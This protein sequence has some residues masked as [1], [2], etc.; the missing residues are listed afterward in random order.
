MIGISRIVDSPRR[1]RDGPGLP[2]ILVREIRVA[3]D[4]EDERFKLSR[5]AGTPAAPTRGLAKPFKA[6]PS[7]PSV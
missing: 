7:V 4:D 1:P 3:A 5:E 2:Q 6:R